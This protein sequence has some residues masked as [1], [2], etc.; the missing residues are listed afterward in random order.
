MKRR[1]LPILIIAALLAAVCSVGPAGDPAPRFA[2][3]EPEDGLYPYLAELIRAGVLEGGQGETF[4]PDQPVGWREAV[5]LLLRALGAEWSGDPG[6]AA[7]EYKLLYTFDGA[8][9]SGGPTR[10][11]AARM[12]AR[13]LELLP[14]AGESPYSDCDDGYVV[15][16]YERG[17][18]EEETEFRPDDPLTRG[19]LAMLAWH[20]MEADV[21]GGAFRYSN[22]WVET[23][24][25]VPAFGYDTAA[26]RWEEDRPTY[27]GAGY[28]ALLGVDVSG[29]QGDIDW[30]A[31]KADGVDFALIRVGGRFIN[32]GGLYDDSY[33]EKNVEGALAAGLRVGVYFFSQAVNEEEGLEEAEYVL[34]RIRDYDITMPVIIDWEYLGGSDA[35][36]YGVEPAEITDGVAAFCRR[37]ADAGYQPMVYFNSYCGYIKMDLR[38]LADWGF[39]FAQYTEVPS[40]A[41]HFSMWQYTNK[42]QVDGISGDVDMNLYFMAE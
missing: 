39:W 33:F 9:P 29:Y 30:Q 10:L 17:L 20:V 37:V 8:W 27:T 23:L 36:T 7:V 32:S 1:A 13:G 24:A 34:E 14:F 6:A 12:A 4:G 2:D 18:L 42:G 31:V 21:S 22:Y 19:E 11:E 16:L 26:F 28:A 5:T 41:Y 15:K 25:E 40:F 35:R 3:L 38:R